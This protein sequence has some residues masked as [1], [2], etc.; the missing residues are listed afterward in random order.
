[1]GC[2]GLCPRWAIPA[3]NKE[4]YKRMKKEGHVF[5]Q[6]RYTEDVVRCSTCAVRM[7][8]IGTSKCPCCHYKLRMGPRNRT[9]KQ[10]VKRIDTSDVEGARVSV[11]VNKM[12]EDVS[13]LMACLN[14]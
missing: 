6:K 14:F 13:T 9:K 1:M 3:Y 7:P 4:D 10:N 2:N 11:I 5:S 8:Y 12:S